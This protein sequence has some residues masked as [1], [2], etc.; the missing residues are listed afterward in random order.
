MQNHEMINLRF[1]NSNVHTYV[2]IYTIVNDKHTLY[3]CIHIY[4]YI[5]AKKIKID[6]IVLSHNHS[7]IQVK[8]FF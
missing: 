2:C 7:K 3:M 5:K 1:C 8:I 6:E 4:L